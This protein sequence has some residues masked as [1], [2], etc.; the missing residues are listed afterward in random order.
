MSDCRDGLT[1]LR[2]VRA[3]IRLLARFSKN[4]GLKN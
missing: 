4:P 2:P 3:N 1:M